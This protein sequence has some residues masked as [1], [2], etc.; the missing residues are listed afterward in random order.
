MTHCGPFHEHQLPGNL[1]EF[2][3]QPVSLSALVY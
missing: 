1:A 3:V 2:G